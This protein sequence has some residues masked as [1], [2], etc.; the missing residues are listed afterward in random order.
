[1]DVI[2]RKIAGDAL[3]M[4]AAPVGLSGIAM[5]GDL[6]QFVSMGSKRIP[7]VRDDGQV[8][9]TVA[10]A[11]GETSRTITGYATARPLVRATEGTAATVSYDAS[12]G[13]FNVKV[14]PSAGGQTTL[15]IRPRGQRPSWHIE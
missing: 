6:G 12:T 7:A 8:H 5:L 11:S 13:L 2:Q 4:I 14:T 15:V 9:L 1:A 10:F 3:Y